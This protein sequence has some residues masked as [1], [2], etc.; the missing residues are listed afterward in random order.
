MKDLGIDF[1]EDPVSFTVVVK[2]H[3][4]HGPTA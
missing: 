1:I 4:I 2:D 3:Q